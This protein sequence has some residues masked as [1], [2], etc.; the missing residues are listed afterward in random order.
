[1]HENGLSN[2]QTHEAFSSQLFVT[3]PAMRKRKNQTEQD[4]KRTVVCI[5]YKVS[6]AD[7]IDVNYDEFLKCTQQC[8]LNKTNPKN[9]S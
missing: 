2:K 3:P 9:K 5:Q 7:K 4:K 6:T 1:M 8:R